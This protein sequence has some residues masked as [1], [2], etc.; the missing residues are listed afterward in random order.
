M[1]RKYVPKSK[2]KIPL[3][4]VMQR[5]GEIVGDDLD[6]M[7]RYTVKTVDLREISKALFHALDKCS[8]KWWELYKEIQRQAANNFRDMK[9][10]Q[11][12]VRTHKDV[13]DPSTGQPM[14]TVV[15]P[16]TKKA[17]II[18]I[19]MNLPDG[20]LDVLKFWAYDPVQGET[21]I[22]CGNVEYKVKDTTELMKFDEM[23]IKTLGRNHIQVPDEY[24]ICGK[25]FA[26]VMS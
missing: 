6:R 9:T 22:V 8:R 16:P 5:R 20:S 2:K 10:A 3:S 1:E 26:R 14:K 17:T 12:K 19:P 11:S 18:P 24:E 15:W 23:D 25:S 21:L 13:M 4:I 7:E